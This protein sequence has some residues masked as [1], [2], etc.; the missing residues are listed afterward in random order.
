[1]LSRNIGEEEAYNLIRN[2]AMTK[3]MTTEEIA[4][5]VIKANEILGLDVK[6]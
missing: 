5:A 1:M 3:R 2:R 4:D 6:G